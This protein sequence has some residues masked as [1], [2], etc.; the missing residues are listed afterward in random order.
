MFCNPTPLFLRLLSFTLAQIL[1]VGNGTGYTGT[2]SPL[3]PFLF[4][5]AGFGRTVAPVKRSEPQ[6]G[7]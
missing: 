4:V 3:S 1:S 7:S 6:I 5:R 2:L